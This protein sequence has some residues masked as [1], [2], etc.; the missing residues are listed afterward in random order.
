[1]I[2][3]IPLLWLY[4]RS[5]LWEAFAPMMALIWPVSLP[6]VIA[7]NA[8]CWVRSTH[9]RFKHRNDPAIDWAGVFSGGV[10]LSEPMPDVTKPMPG[11]TRGEYTGFFRDSD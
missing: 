4:N 11:V 7:F 1:M 8:Y 6:F 3:I 10:R 2:P 9:D 5:Y